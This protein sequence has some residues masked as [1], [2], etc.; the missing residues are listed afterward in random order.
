MS[1]EYYKIYGIFI[2][3]IIQIYNE[4]YIQRLRSLICGYF[5]PKREKRR[6]K[7]LYK[8]LLHQRKALYKIMSYTINEYISNSIN[9]ELELDFIIV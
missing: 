7:Y 9:K 4:P 5:H 1:R 6:I 2:I 3:I 8:K